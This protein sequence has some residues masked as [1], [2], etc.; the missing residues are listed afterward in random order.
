MPNAT[1]LEEK[2]AAVAALTEKVK[3]A[4]AGVLVSYTGI[5][6]SDDTA[7]RKK[8]RD[9]GVEY[10]VVK[11]SILRFAFKDA[12]YEELDEHLNGASALA[13]S[14]DPVAAA[15]II[16][17]FA[18]S[19]ENSKKEIPFSVKAGFI[20]GK[21]IDAEGVAA[22]AKLPSREILVATVLGTL[23]A[24]ITG[25]VTVLNGTIKGLA[26]AINAIA[27]KKSAETPAAS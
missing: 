6:V 4:T 12:G 14:S 1:I 11:N 22:L 5:S 13:L 18:S 7:L 27:E 20:D 3:A 15:K 17:E 2:K 26:C 23:N 8:L 9:A 21:C 25:F 24:P 16:S 10:T 19:P